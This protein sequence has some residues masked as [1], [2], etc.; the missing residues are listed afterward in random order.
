[1]PISTCYSCQGDYAWNWEEAFEKFGFNDGDGLVATSSVIEVLEEPGYTVKAESFSIHNTVITSI[2]K[3]DT[4]FIPESTKV[5]YDDPRD[6]LPRDITA[7][8]DEK[9][10]AG[11][12]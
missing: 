3:G 11:Y 8:L 4:Q 1:M 9:L 6:Y 12:Y 2:I 10:P 5:G 7:L